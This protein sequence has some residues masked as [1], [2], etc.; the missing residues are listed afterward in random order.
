MNVI[1]ERISDIQ[2][3]SKRHQ[4]DTC[5]GRAGAHA[6][7]CRSAGRLRA[8]AR[9]CVLDYVACTLAGASEELADILLAEMRGAGRRA[10]SPR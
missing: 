2:G 1:T 9:Q 7:L 10:E 5:A 6:E 3:T 4:A 8:L